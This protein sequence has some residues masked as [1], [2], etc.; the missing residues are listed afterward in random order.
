M[1]N[2]ITVDIS[3]LKEV[4]VIK[5]ECYCCY[6]EDGW[7]GKCNACQKKDL[8]GKVKKEIQLEEEVLQ[9][10]INETL[11]SKYLYKDDTWKGR[12]VSKILRKLLNL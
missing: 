4:K 12:I 7:N 1:A 11:D 3:T 2:H 5:E 6:L 8:R 10:K 9:N